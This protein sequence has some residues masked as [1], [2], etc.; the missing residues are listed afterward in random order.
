MHAA[1]SRKPPWRRV[2]GSPPSLVAAAGFTGQASTPWPERQGWPGP[3]PMDKA[4]V[5]TATP[6]PGR[7]CWSGS[8]SPTCHHGCSAGTPFL[9][10]AILTPPLCCGVIPQ[11]GHALLHKRLHEALQRA[12]AAR[13]TAARTPRCP[14][15]HATLHGHRVW[16]EAPPC[17]ASAAGAPRPRG[18]GSRSH[19]GA[20]PLTGPRG[21]RP[22][23]PLT[24]SD[25][26]ASFRMS[27]EPP[28]SKQ[29]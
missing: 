26:G 10:T 23:A 28:V 4:S 11:R 1:S 3:R 18:H 6:C 27:P 15:K 29:K 8:P 22:G 9:G 21:P 20:S 19:R 5:D 2:A 25:V 12:G 13:P 14:P 7:A 17:P 24:I 16:A